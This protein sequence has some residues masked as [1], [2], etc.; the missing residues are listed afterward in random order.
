MGVLLSSTP[1]TFENRVYF[2][3]K[4]FAPKGSKFFPFRV[5]PF[6]EDPFSVA[7][8]GARIIGDLEVVVLI[9]TGSGNI[10]SWRLIMKYF[11]WSFSSFS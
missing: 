2:K 3:R 5:D 10:L 4:E 11:L 9:V 6:S 1:N 8:S 7:Q